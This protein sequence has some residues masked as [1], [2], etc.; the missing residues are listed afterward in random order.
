MILYITYIFMISDLYSWYSWYCWYN[1]LNI[2]NFYTLK[3]MNMTVT[4]ADSNIWNLGLFFFEASVWVYGYAFSSQDKIYIWAYM[5]ENFFNVKNKFIDKHPYHLPVLRWHFNSQI[6]IQRC[7]K[8]G[9]NRLGV[10]RSA[11][12]SYNAACAAAL[13]C[14]DQTLFSGGD[15]KDEQCTGSGKLI[16]WW[17]RCF[18]GIYSQ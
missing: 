8:D 13:D 9:D 2:A 12:R 7:D 11:C 5:A 15:E 4:G 3:C 17:A 6:S 10:C 18:K 14:S 1:I 16:P